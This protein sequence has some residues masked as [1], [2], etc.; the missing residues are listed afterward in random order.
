M[1]P[2]VCNDGWEHTISD[3]LTIHDY[4]ERGEKLFQRFRDK[5]EYLKTEM[6]AA[7]G[8]KRIFAEGY[9]YTGQPVIISEFG[10]IAFS[11]EEGWGYGN[12][13]KDEGAFLERFASIHKA[14]QDIPYIGGYCYTQ[15]S[16]VEQEINGIVRAD[17]S[18]KLPLDGLREINDR[19]SSC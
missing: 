2:V 5:E 8:L 1:R 16:D 15:V 3:I 19:R 12:M 6:N 17:R 10:G 14:I 7:N 13:V 9:G 18:T 11:A 4:E